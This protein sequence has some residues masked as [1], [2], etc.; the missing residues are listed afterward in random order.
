MSCQISWYYD[1]Q[2]GETATEYFAY[3]TF[4]PLLSQGEYANGV[5]LTLFDCRGMVGT[6]LVE[7]LAAVTKALEILGNL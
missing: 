6:C 4:F 3:I 5:L 2:C 7:T 1:W